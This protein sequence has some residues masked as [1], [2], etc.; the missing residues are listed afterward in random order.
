MISRLARWWLNRTKA[1]PVPEYLP[2]GECICGKRVAG[3][4]WHLIVAGQDDQSLGI[5]D[6]GSFMSADFCA[7]H[8][9]GGCRQG[10]PVVVP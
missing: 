9:P 1:R 2:L 6:G 5:G 4:D 3:A 7:D 10:C 8:C